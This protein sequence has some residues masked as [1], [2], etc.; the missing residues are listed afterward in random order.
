MDVWI[1]FK[2]ATK[3]QAEG[4]FKCFFP[5]APAPS[6]TPTPAATEADATK[7]GTDKGTLPAAPSRR[8]Q[9][10]HGVPLLTAE[11]LETLAKKF[12]AAIPEDEMSVASL[13]G[14]LLKN[15]VRLPPS[16]GGPG[17]CWLNGVIADPAS[18][19]RGGGSR[20]GQDRAR[21]EGEAQ[22]GEGRGT[23]MRAALSSLLTFWL[24][25]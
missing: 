8:K 7:P 16:R 23:F 5:S 4:I 3:W 1:N 11:E 19:V 21:D 2:N 17:R 24:L 6:A 9:H 14:Y 12:A 13:Q 10:I 25:A 20:M 18:G 22:E 15:K